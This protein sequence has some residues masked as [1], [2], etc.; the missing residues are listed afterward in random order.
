MIV[1]VIFS[2]WTSTVSGL[3]LLLNEPLSDPLQIFFNLRRILARKWMLSQLCWPC[4]NS[5]SAA[6]ATLSCDLSAPLS[7]TILGDGTQSTRRSEE[8]M[9]VVCMKIEEQTLHKP[10]MTKQRSVSSSKRQE[11]EWCRAVRHSFL[12][13]QVPPIKL[14]WAF[15]RFQQF[16]TG[17][18]QWKSKTNYD[19]RERAAAKVA[20]LLTVASQT[21]QKVFREAKT[22]FR[23]TQFSEEQK[24]TKMQFDHFHKLVSFLHSLELLLA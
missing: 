10:K 21:V 2:F 24:K 6:K 17:Y 11:N 8:R 19:M 14:F 18:R 5:Q 20:M 16:E 23:K 12:G 1:V 22:A 4:L 7:Q 13:Y 9:K 3:L 15:P